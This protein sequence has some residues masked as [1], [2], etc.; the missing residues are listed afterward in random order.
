VLK[1]SKPDNDKELRILHQIEQFPVVI[2]VGDAGHSV[3]TQIPQFLVETGWTE[4]G[5][6]VGCVSSGADSCRYSA[7]LIADEMG[8]YVGGQV[9]YIV[10]FDR[11]VSAKSKVICLT[12]NALVRDIL[13]DPLLSEYSV[14]ILDA[15]HKREIYTEIL[16][17]ILKKILKKRPEFR[18][19]LLSA[20][21]AIEDF[22][23]YFRNL[24]MAK[25]SVSAISIENRAYPGMCYFDLSS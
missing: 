7:R 8:S 10:N 4:Q 6:L 3:S 2:V 22:Q 5:R 17:A 11:A 16:L 13:V 9:G 12:P 1:S 14:I 15:V 20:S 18:L 23:L 24:N 25:E 21:D 19:V